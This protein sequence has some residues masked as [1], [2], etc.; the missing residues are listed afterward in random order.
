MKNKFLLVVIGLTTF[1]FNSCSNEDNQNETTNTVLLKKIVQTNP[2]GTITSDAY[3]SG[4]KIINEISSNGY[5]GKYYYTGDLITKFERL[6]NN[7]LKESYIYSYNSSGKVISCNVNIVGNYTG[8]LTINY[9]NDGS[10]NYNTAFTYSSSTVVENKSYTA[11]ILNNEIATFTENGSNIVYT[12]TYDSKKSARKNILGFDKIYLANIESIIG[13]YQ[14]VIQVKRNNIIKKTSIYTYNTEEYP[15]TENVSY[16]SDFGTL[17]S[18]KNI[19][20]YY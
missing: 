16:Y 15:L 6:Q 10:I 13:C 5:E 7:I 1:L 19:A 14:N 3:Y 2:Q 18:T 17:Q 11:T 9:N 4:N 20:Y 12:Y 8:T